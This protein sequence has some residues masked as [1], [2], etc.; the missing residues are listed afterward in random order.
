MFKI[1]FHVLVEK[2]KVVDRRPNYRLPITSSRNVDVDKI[3][4]YYIDDSFKETE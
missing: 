2:C 4:K 1:Y 3:I